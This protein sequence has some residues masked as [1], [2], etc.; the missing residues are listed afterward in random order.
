MVCHSL[1]DKLEGFFVLDTS[2]SDLYVCLADFLR[3]GFAFAAI[4][5]DCAANVETHY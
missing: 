2:G 4:E 5:Y 3:A 1:T